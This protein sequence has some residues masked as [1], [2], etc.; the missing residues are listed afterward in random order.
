[1]IVLLF[2]VQSLYVGTSFKPYM[3]QAVRFCRP[4]FV[5]K[6]LSTANFALTQRVKVSYLVLGQAETHSVYNCI[7]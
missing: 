7:S 3:L 2:V 1:M 4:F 6:P 5:V